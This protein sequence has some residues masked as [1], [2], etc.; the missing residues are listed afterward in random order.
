[1]PAKETSI[2]PSTEPSTTHTWSMPHG[3]R[4]EL[5]PGKTL[6]QWSCIT[7]QRHFVNEPAIAEWFAAFPRTLDFERLDAVS[8]LWLNEDCPGRHLASDENVRKS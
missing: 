4:L 5:E 7:C 6:I 8:E 2:V 3:R 1:M